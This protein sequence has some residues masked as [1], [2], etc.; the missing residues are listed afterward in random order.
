MIVKVRWQRLFLAACLTFLSTWVL[1]GIDAK[2]IEKV[3]LSTGM[4][5]LRSPWSFCVTEDEMLIIPDFPEGNIKIGKKDGK[6]HKT[7]GWKGFGIDELLEPAF[8]FYNKNEGKLGVFD[9]GKREIIIY[10]RTGE[11]FRRVHNISCPWL[12]YDIQLSGDLLLI[13]GFKPDQD[14]KPYE[15]Y[16][17][18]IKNK[19]TTYLLPSYTKYGLKSFQEYEKAYRGDLA[20]KVIGRKGYF[21]V[22]EEDVY[23]VW[24]GDLK[25]HKINLG[26][27]EIIK[28]FGFKPNHYIKPYASNDLRDGY[29]DGDEKKIQ[30]EQSKMSYIRRIFTTSNYVLLIYEGPVR[31][32]SEPSVWLQFYTLDGRFIREMA[33]TLQRQLAYMMNFD[34]DRNILYLLSKKQSNEYPEYFIL[35]YKILE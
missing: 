5:T 6:L 23:F 18:N 16:Y 31:S 24:E 4:E 14:Q 1:W 13:S 10:D 35:K 28:S 32:D 15:L 29:I 19:Q 21:D 27:G 12:G 9:F 34:K 30:N 17:E 26:S 8:C 20:I 11:E 7:I 2:L 33:I 22:W 3:Q 25:I